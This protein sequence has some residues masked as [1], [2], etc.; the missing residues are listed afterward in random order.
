MKEVSLK[1]Q[2][3]TFDEQ[4]LVVDLECFSLQYHSKALNIRKDLLRRE[5]KFLALQEIHHKYFSGVTKSTQTNDADIRI[6]D[7]IIVDSAQ[8]Y[9]EYQYS[10]RFEVDRRTYDDRNAYLNHPYRFDEF[11]IMNGNASN[12]LNN[13]YVNVCAFND[14]SDDTVDASISTQ[15]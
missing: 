9:S 5:A 4:Q 10:H 11:K 13:E 8:Y 6:N 3:P 15:N 12:D 2:I 1:F 7:K 14:T